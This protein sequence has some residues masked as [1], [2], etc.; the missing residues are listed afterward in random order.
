LLSVYAHA[1]A[2]LVEPGEAVARGQL[3]GKIGETG[4]LRGPFLYFELR[5]DGKPV[6]PRLWLRPR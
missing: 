5:M 3:L 6:D 1:S 2:L 4:S